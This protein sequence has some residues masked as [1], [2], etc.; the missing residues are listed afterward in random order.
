MEAYNDDLE[1]W[2]SYQDKIEQGKEKAESLNRRFARWYYVIAGEDYDKLALSRNDLV[3]PKEEVKE[4]ASET[5]PQSSTEES[6]AANQAAADEF[7][8]ENQ[9]KDGVITTESGLQYEVL[10]EG[11]GASPSE[12]SRV[13]VRYKGMLLDGT[14]FDQSGDSAVEF[15]VNQ[16]I[17]GW[18]EALQLMRP[19]AKWKL[20]IPPE[21][22]Y[23]ER[24]SGDKIGPN[25]LLI[26]EVELVSVEPNVG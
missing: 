26:F 13:K 14:V 17:P 12:G 1:A 2:Q 7:L 21:L 15:G 9:S 6:A 18:T 11:E 25:T 19:G 10:T 4:P 8:A 24:G 22:A 20:Y 16:V 23:G 5:E 3:E